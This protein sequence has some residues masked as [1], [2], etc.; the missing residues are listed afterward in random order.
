MHTVTFHAERMQNPRLHPTTI[1][2]LTIRW[3]HRLIARDPPSPYLHHLQLLAATAE[4]Y[5]HQRPMDTI[6]ACLREEAGPQEARVQERK[7]LHTWSYSRKNRKMKR[8]ALITGRGGK[9]T[10][11]GGAPQRSLSISNSYQ[12]CHPPKCQTMIWSL[13]AW[14]LQRMEMNILPLQPENTRNHQPS[15]TLSRASMR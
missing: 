10:T 4:R 11:C 6:A 7:D 5:L 13:Q 12:V 2:L 9:K 1:P 8:N 14:P 15:T 3:L